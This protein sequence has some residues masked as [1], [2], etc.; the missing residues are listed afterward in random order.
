MIVGRI[1]E[2]CLGLSLLIMASAWAIRLLS[3]K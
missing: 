1:L 2:I 3:D